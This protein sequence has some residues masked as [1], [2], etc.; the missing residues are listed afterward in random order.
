MNVCRATKRDGTP[1]TLPATAP[2]GLCW[3]HSPQHAERRRKLASHA[4]RAKRHTPRRQVQEISADLADLY[5][6]VLAG[7]VSPKV[8]AVA[9]QVANTRIRA[10]ET[11]RRW[12]ETDE[13]EERIDALEE[14][15]R[16]IA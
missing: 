2:D 1:C 12:H 15:S 5:T 8:A 16:E 14:R 10:L 3:A 7:R 11:E 6:D 9:A 13:L 4:A